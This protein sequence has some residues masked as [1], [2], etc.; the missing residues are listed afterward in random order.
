MLKFIFIIILYSLAP[1]T[2]AVEY[3]CLVEKKFNSEITYTPQDLKKQKFS[4]KIEDNNKNSYLSRCSYSTIKSKVTCDRYKVD[5]IVFDEH[6]KI[7]KY[8][9]FSSHFDVQLYPNMTFVEN[10]G[11]GDIAYGT[12]QVTSP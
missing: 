9:I 2:W 10:N 12:C 5:K 4:V 11:R 1:L 7:K 8:Y 3:N 6:V